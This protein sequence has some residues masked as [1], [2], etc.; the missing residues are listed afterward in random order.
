MK[1]IIVAVLFCVG[2][3]SVLGRPEDNESSV[4][5]V[6]SESHHQAEQSIDDSAEDEASAKT[7]RGIL[8]YDAGHSHLHAHAA[9]PQLHA[10]AAYP[11]VHAH[12]VYPQLH[13]QAAYPHVHAHTAYPHVHS[14]NYAVPVGLHKHTVAT[15][16]ARL[17]GIYRSLNSPTG[18]VA[19]THGGA[20]V[21]S[22]SVNYPRVPVVAAR[23]VLH[24]HHPVSVVPVA[25]PA[26]VPVQPTLIPSPAVVVPQRP[27]IPVA[28]SSH[29]HF[30]RVPIYVQ[31]P[32][33]HVLS[34]PV[35]PVVVHKP[36]VPAVAPAPFFPTAS[37]PH[38]HHQHVH[39]VQP[40]IPHVLPQTPVQPQFFPIPSSPLPSFPIGTNFGSPLPQPGVFNNAPLPGIFNSAPLPGGWRPIAVPSSASPLPAGPF[41]GSPTQGLL[42]PFESSPTTHTHTEIQPAPAGEQ[43]IETPFP[44]TPSSLYLSPGDINQLDNANNANYQHY[45]DA[46]QEIAN[47]HGT[48]Y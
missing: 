45:S 38:V 27:I 11:H 20:S 41:A 48:F 32:H 31:R 12:A 2:F 10:Q 6:E 42:P 25:R 46:A 33:V 26:I 8:H 34:R 29:T 47:S 4:D 16:Y 35:T 1:V 22:Y 44:Q 7:K 17:P 40:Q 13:A 3:N 43:P 36:I 24:H 15:P 21:Q 23:P 30:H 28:V 5:V 14:V 39:P 19:L 18:H 9:Y 37:I